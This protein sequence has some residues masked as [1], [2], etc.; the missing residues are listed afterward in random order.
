MFRHSTNSMFSLLHSL[1]LVNPL[2]DNVYVFISRFQVMFLKLSFKQSLPSR[3]FLPEQ[4]LIHFKMILVNSMYKES[5]NL[6]IIVLKKTIHNL[7]HAIFRY[8]AYS[9]NEIYSTEEVRELVKYA[10]ARGVR[11]VIEIDSPAHAGNG[12]QWGKVS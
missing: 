1:K 12:W 7:C 11:M 8:G 10:Q 5:L 4:A 2:K 3:T 9:P 6:T